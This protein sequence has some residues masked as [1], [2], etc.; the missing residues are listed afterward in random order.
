MTLASSRAASRWAGLL[1]A[2]APQY[3]QI[4]VRRCEVPLVVAVEVPLA[5]AVEVPLVVAIV[6]PLVMASGA[7]NYV[8][9]CNVGNEG[10]GEGPLDSMF[11]VGPDIFSNGGKTPGSLMKRNWREWSNGS[12][13]VSVEG[14][15]S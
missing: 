7:V 9:V 11:V 15:G 4:L 6:A 8:E 13:W 10:T 12:K 1:P 14:R 3:T 5:V 2:F